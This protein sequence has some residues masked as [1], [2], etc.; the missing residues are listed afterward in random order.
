MI[1]SVERVKGGLG[2]CWQSGGSAVV[3][4]CIQSGVG[5]FDA[6]DQT[7]G[8]IAGL[9]QVPL[10]QSGRAFDGVLQF[11]HVAGPI[12]GAE[13]VHCLTRDLEGTAATSVEL[14]FEEVSDQ[15]GNVL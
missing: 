5:G 2:H 10:A 14:A 13:E 1:V 12:V 11:A 7:G 15:Q 8:Q 4:S 9:D 3:V 6:G